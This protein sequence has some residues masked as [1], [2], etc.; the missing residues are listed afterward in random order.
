MPTKFT[1]EEDR[2]KREHQISGTITDV[3]EDV[4]PCCRVVL[5]EENK[6]GGSSTYTLDVS[7]TPFSLEEL[8]AAIGKRMMIQVKGEIKNAGRKTGSRTV[9]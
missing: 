6:H 9:S 8:K 5:E 4:G 2:V 3:Y 7:D 1:K